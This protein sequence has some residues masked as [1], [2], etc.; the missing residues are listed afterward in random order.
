MSQLSSFYHLALRDLHAAAGATFTVHGG[1]SLPGSYGDMAAEL[2]AI[3]EHAAVFDRSQRSRILVTGTDAADVL[4]A[5]F[6]GYVNELEEGRA[7][8]TVALDERGRITDLVLIARTGGI[9]YLVLGEPGQ[10]FDTLM[11]LREAVQEDYDAQVDDRT[12]TTCLIA[13]NGPE[14]ANTAREHLSDAL[15]SRLQ[16]LHC[17]T[18]VFHGFR[19]MAIRTSDTGEDGFEFMFAPAVAQH[20]IETLRNVKVP[21]AGFDAQEIARVEACVPAYDPDLAPGLSPAEADLDVLLGIPGGAEGRILSG[22]ILD[23]EEAVPAGTPVTKDGREVGQIR[24]CVRSPRLNAT[25]A[26]GIIES[27]EALPGTALVAAG[28]PADIV[29]KPF[30]RRRPSG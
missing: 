27:R 25:I 16:T 30:L 2:A 23:H 26:L 22:L 13:L 21:L 14:A 29:A 24:S 11:R 12:E 1:W 7:M 10:R 6:Q 3:R 4:G 8:R 20:M 5:V 9:A 28:S 15:P 18:F 19:S 17:V